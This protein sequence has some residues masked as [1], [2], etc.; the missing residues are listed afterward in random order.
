MSKSSTTRT[1]TNPVVD[2]ARRWAANILTEVLH[3]FGSKITAQQR[4]ALKAAVFEL[5][6]GFMEPDAGVRDES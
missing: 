2:A 6:V 1:E 3:N 5:T 4:K